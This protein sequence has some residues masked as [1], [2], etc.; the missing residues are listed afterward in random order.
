M[1]RRKGRHAI[2]LVLLLALGPVPL[3]AQDQDAA[4]IWP[5]DSVL[6]R[7]EHDIRANVVPS[8]G[9]HL[10]FG[11]LDLPQTY[12]A[13]QDSLLDGLEHLALTSNNP[14]VRQRAASRLA[15]AGAAERESPPLPRVMS[16]LVRLYWA[17]NDAGV[18]LAIRNRLPLQAERGA[19]AALLRAVAAE[20]DPVALRPDLIG[21]DRAE[22]LARLSEMGEDGR[23]V[24]REMHRSGEA[25]SPQARAI[26]ED[27]ARRGFPV[28]DIR[29]RRQ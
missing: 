24:L 21:D 14:I 7:W 12:H 18:R 8:L 16:R 6:A 27:M 9:S 17:Q 5:I 29:R 10:V 22:A 13:R 15:Y 26:L 11:I 23:A 2:L 1:E 25:R 4:R 3:L 20:A 28:R 19:A